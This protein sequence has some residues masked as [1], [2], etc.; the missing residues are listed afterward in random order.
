MTTETLRLMCILMLRMAE[1]RC[2]DREDID[3]MY[4]ISKHSKVQAVMSR[5]DELARSA[6]GKGEKWAVKIVPQECEL[7]HVTPNAL[8]L[9]ER[10]G[11]TCYRSEDRITEDSAEKFVAMLVKRGHLSVLEHAHAT[12]RLVTDRG[13]SHE[14]VRHR[15]GISYSQ[16]STRYCNYDRDKF[17]GG[18][19]IIEPPGVRVSDRIYHAWFDSL[20]EAESAYL[21]LI[22]EGVVPEIARSVLPTCLKTEIAVT[23]NFREWLEV[24]RQRT[25]KAAHPQIR[26][27]IGMVRDTL[28]KECPAVFGV[29]HE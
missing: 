11:R 8:Q 23:A 29:I 24:I 10:A 9:I 2:E 1:E 20:V 21:A 3:V 19:T 25:S 16:E 22:A 17:G 13:V 4:A 12:F 5:G 26:E 14:L 18:I 27:L 15:V 6:N 7:L 28:A